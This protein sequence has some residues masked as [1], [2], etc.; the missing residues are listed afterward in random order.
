MDISLEI[1]VLWIASLK[2]VSHADLSFKLCAQDI[3]IILHVPFVDISLLRSEPLISAS[4]WFSNGYL[5]YNKCL[6]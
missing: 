4:S 2:Q 1:G 6:H 3:S 5:S